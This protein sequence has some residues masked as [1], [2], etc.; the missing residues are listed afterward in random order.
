VLGAIL[1]LSNRTLPSP[2]VKPHHNT[3]SWDGGAEP[4]EENLRKFCTIRREKVLKALEWLKENNELYRDVKINY[5]L[6]HAWPDDAVP[7]ELIQNAVR[8]EPGL[9]DHRE[10]YSV[11]RETSHNNMQYDFLN[12]N[13]PDE[14]FENEMDRQA[15]DAEID[16][17]SIV[18]GAFLQDTEKENETWRRG[19]NNQSIV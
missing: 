6:L 15:C 19:V 13:G 17:G 10:G 14:V 16:P 3:V 12:P 11:D 5:K 1:L 2:E 7:P 4:T 18:T 9:S 8:T